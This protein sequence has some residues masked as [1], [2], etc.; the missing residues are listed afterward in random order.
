[1]A[2]NSLPRNP[3]S[4]LYLL[5]PS[6]LS[7]R[8]RIRPSSFPLIP[9]LPFREPRLSELHL[10]RPA[11]FRSLRGLPQVRMKAATLGSKKE[12]VGL[13]NALS[14]STQNAYAFHA[15]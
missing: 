9:R 3:E 1:M 8:L 11:Y 10:R 2:G 15:E 4:P 13:S 6:I 5:G 14:N 12:T 7:R